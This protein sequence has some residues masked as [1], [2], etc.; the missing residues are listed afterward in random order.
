MEE[1]YIEDEE[2]TVKNIRSAYM[3]RQYEYNEASVNRD[4]ND[5]EYY[6]KCMQTLLQQMTPDQREWCLIDS[7]EVPEA[8]WSE[9]WANIKLHEGD[10]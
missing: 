4:H 8:M 7:F 5:M 1:K 10:D 9:M 3:Q 6:D 2:I